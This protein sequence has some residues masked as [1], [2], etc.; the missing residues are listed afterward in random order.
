MTKWLIVMPISNQLP[1]SRTRKKKLIPI[2]S[3]RMRDSRRLGTKGWQRRQVMTLYEQLTKTKGMAILKMRRPPMT[4]GENTVR[5]QYTLRTSNELILAMFP[6]PKKESRPK[7][8]QNVIRLTS[9]TE[10]LYG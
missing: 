1:E 8:R 9:S 5:K 6:M 2:K 10:N 7:K 3:E 4:N